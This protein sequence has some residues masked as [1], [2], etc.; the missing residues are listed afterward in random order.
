MINFMKRNS[1]VSLILFFSLA[2]QALPPRRTVAN[3]DKE[4]ADQLFNVLKE[5]CRNIY[6]SMAEPQRTNLCECVIRAYR[7]K[8]TQV[9]FLRMLAKKNLKLYSEEEL[10]QIK[11][12]DDFNIIENFEIDVH[13]SCKKDPQFEI[14]DE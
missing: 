13:D 10:K 4:N 1:I 9:E 6:K 12:T 7:K 11:K 2:S 5:D 8:L 14:K 3:L